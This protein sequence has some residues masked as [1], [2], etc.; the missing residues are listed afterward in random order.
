MSD[1]ETNTLL[2]TFKWT[3]GM[4]GAGEDT[5]IAILYMKIYEFSAFNISTPVCV[6]FH[7]QNRLSLN[8]VS[9]PVFGKCSDFLCNFEEISIILIHF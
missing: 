7:V 6:D 1:G 8:S 3:C 4:I 2:Q 9:I 5:L